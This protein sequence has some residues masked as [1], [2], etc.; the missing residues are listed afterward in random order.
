MI[1]HPLCRLKLLVDQLEINQSM[2]NEKEP[3]VFADEDN[4]VIKLWVPE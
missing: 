1:N 3:K 4:V 2:F